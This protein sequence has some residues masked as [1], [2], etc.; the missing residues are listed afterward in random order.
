M[1]PLAAS[2][3]PIHS[4]VRSSGSS[5]S[6]LTQ[7]SASAPVRP[8]AA[9]IE[10]RPPQQVRSLVAHSVRPFGSWAR[11][12][13]LPAVLVLFTERRRFRFHPTTHPHVIRTIE[14]QPV[15]DAIPPSTKPAA[16]CCSVRRFGSQLDIRPGTNT[17]ATWRPLFQL[18]S[19]PHPPH[20][21][22]P[23]QHRLPLQ[24]RLI[25]TNFYLLRK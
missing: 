12:P 11:V 24:Q 13:R 10:R 18:K 9:R 15:V 21:K 6:R 14:I 4:R 7:V 3:V 22:H 17:N 19:A 25:Q 20:Q 2:A 5:V 23:S 1:R 16:P 8:S